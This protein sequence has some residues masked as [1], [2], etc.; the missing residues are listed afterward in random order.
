MALAL[1]FLSVADMTM[2]W[3]ILG[4]ELFMGLWVLIF[5]A[6]TLYLFGYIRFPHDSPMK[7]LSPVRM[8]FA[9]LSLV[10]TAYLCTGFLFNDKTKAYN[11]LGLMSGLAPPAH[12]NYFL[13]EPVVDKTI[14][15]RFPS[16]TKTCFHH[17]FEEILIAF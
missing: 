10:T 14:K 15:K 7:K 8:G 16:F 12:Y 3:N 6:M 17:P 4:Y 11:S 9:L 5:A 1:K 2:G 13:P